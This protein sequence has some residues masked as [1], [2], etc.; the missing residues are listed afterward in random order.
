M[1]H[2]HTME[3]TTRKR[4][5]GIVTKEIETERE[6]PTEEVNNRKRERE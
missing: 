6:R 4:W 2:Q 3:E 1:S 5:R